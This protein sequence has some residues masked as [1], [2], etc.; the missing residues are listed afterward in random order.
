MSSKCRAT[1]LAAGCGCV[2][3]CRPVTSKELLGEAFERELAP[4]GCSYLPLPSTLHFF[5][6]WKSGARCGDAAVTLLQQKLREKIGA[7]RKKE[8]ASLPMPEQLLD[9]RLPLQRGN[10]PLTQQGLRQVFR[11]SCGLCPRQHGAWGGREVV[12]EDPRL[13]PVTEDGDKSKHAPKFPEN[14]L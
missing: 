9:S 8:A 7:G 13:L 4:L 14:L 5:P 1:A 2:T 12:G 10:K 11:Y 6:S 3:W